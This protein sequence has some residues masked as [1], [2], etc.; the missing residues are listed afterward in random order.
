M[1]ILKFLGLVITILILSGCV[2]TIPIEKISYHNTVISTGGDGNR[3]KRI[4][5][6]TFSVEDEIILLTTVRWEE[7]EKRAGLHQAVWKW[8]SNGALISVVKR[9]LDFYA[10]PYELWSSMIAT[11]LGPGNHRVELYIDDKLFDKQTFKVT[12]KPAKEEE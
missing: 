10:T 12:E 7:V 9:S 6:D 3:P 11:S 8:Y 5:Q 2:S 1:N 4:N